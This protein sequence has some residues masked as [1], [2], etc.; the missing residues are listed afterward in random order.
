MTI[1]E[2]VETMQGEFLSA[3]NNTLS[4]YELNIIETSVNLPFIRK[5]NSPT[6]MSEQIQ[7]I[8]ANLSDLNYL[9]NKII[10]LRYE[11]N[12][13]YRNEYDRRFTILTRMGRPSKQAIDSEM[14]CDNENLIS[15][16]N[17]LEK[18]DNLISWISNQIKLLEMTIKNYESQKYNR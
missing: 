12:I 6:V 15:S 18:L 1:K 10:S 2:V 13:D 11:I 16:R 17:K 14:H 7:D 9:K 4:D 3:T 8:I 5:F